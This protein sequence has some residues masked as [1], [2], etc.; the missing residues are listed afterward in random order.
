MV[1]PGVVRFHRTRSIHPECLRRARRAARTLCNRLFSNAKSV[2]ATQ[3]CVCVCVCVRARV[4]VGMCAPASSRLDHK[5][6]V[7]VDGVVRRG[8][9]R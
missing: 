2:R 6:L 1:R 3:L 7:P 5:Q 9:R 8:G 4:C